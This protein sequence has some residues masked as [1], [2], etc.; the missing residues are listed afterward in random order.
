MGDIKL[1]IFDLDGTLL[2]AYRA[3]V[4]SFNYTMGRLGYPAQDALVIRRAVGW[5]D[6][7][8]LKPFIRVK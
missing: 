6:A 2:D 8:L 4:R 5:G 3:I 7:R 1:I